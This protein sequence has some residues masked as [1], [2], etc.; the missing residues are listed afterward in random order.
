MKRGLVLLLAVFILTGCSQMKPAVSQ[1]EPEAAPAV[2]ILPTQS[3]PKAE[4]PG[5]P[6]QTQKPLSGASWINFFSK[7][8]PIPLF[9]WFSST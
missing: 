4:E 6:V 5:T 3:L 9:Q 8:V 7:S 1:P 2:T